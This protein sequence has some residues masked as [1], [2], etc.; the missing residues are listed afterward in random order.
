MLCH[1]NNN[2]LSADDQYICNLKVSVCVIALWVL[3]QTNKY[4]YVYGL[5]D[6]ERKPTS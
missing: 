6:L 1:N 4:E 3:V 2:P 5:A